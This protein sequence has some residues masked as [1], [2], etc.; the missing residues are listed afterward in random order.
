MADLRENRRFICDYYTPGMTVIRIIRS[1]VPGGT[2]SGISIPELPQG[3]GIIQYGDI[4]AEKT[5]SV[6]SRSMPLL[7]AAPEGRYPQMSVTTSASLKF[8]PAGTARRMDQI[9]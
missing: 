1:E 6:F 3:A 5:L 9:I 8:R 7:C 2:I 4:P